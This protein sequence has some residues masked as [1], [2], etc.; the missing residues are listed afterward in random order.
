MIQ[1][2]QRFSRYANRI[3]PSAIR[4]LATMAK[5]ADCISFGPGE[6]DSSLFPVAE[7]RDSLARILSQPERTRAA[8]QYGPSEGDP[9]LRERICAYMRAKG[10]ACERQ[11]ILLTNGA[12]Q[13]LD[14]VTELFAEPGA[15]VLVQSPTYP[16]ALQIFFAHGARVQS[17]EM[18]GR[19]ADERP[20]LIYAMSNFHNPTGATLSLAQRRELIALAQELDTVLVE[21]DPYEVLRYEGA[22]LPPLLAVDIEACSIE[23]A[24]TIYLGTFS[25]AIAPGFRVGWLVA[26]SS[27]VA[28]LALMK[29]SEDLQ[30]GSLAQACLRGLFDGILDSHA[31]RLRDAYRIRRDT[32][33]SALQLELGNHASWVAPQGGFFIWLNLNADID[34]HALLSRAAVAGVTYVPGSAFQPDGQ[35]TASLRLSFS[36]APLDRMEE[37]V[38]RLAKVLRDCTARAEDRVAR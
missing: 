11:N 9:A 31:N 38:R 3:V 23:E 20:A 30:A 36:A 8:L 28:K 4:G 21:D 33:L 34:A 22:A 26:P 32:M 35:A 19:A 13:A 29:Q 16:G 18:A 37:G 1:M 5:A 2:E 25:K 17:L 14:L 15:S 12:Q 24:R 10:V 7:I 6:P 27:V